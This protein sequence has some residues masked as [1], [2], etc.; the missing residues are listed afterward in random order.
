MLDDKYQLKQGEKLKFWPEVGPYVIS[1]DKITKTTCNGNIHCL[2]S[3]KSMYDFTLTAPAKVVKFTLTEKS[4]SL[5]NSST[6]IFSDNNCRIQISS[7]KLVRIS[8]SE[9]GA[10]VT[11]MFSKK[12]GPYDPCLPAI[13]PHNLN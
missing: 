8:R 13:L 11:I 1:L 9:L 7:L 6:F 12:A 4:D 5:G 2:W 3:S 10:I